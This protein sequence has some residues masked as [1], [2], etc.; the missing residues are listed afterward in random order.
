M[1]NNNAWTC[2]VNCFLT[3]SKAFFR[4]LSGDPK[5]L[6]DG[7]WRELAQDFLCK[8]SLANRPIF[9]KFRKNSWSICKTSGTIQTI[10]RLCSNWR[11]MNGWKWLYS[12]SK[13]EVHCQHENLD[14]LLNKHIQLSP[15]AW[16]LA[17]QYPVQKI[18]PAFFPDVHLSNPHS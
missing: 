4:Q 10:Y 1:L 18:S 3:T 5:I 2:I 12:I 15:L 8:A 17:Y 9:L 6:D 7:R 14:N 11:I 16:P 13:E